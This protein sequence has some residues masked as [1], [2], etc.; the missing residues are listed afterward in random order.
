MA[1]LNPNQIHQ[2]LSEAGLR[3]KNAGNLADILAANSLSPEDVISELGSMARSA[4]QEPT[5]LK[6]LEL[7]M[8]LNGMLQGDDSKQIPIVNI[9]IQDAQ[10]FSVNPILIPR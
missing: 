1:L 6:A 7:G 5:R 10:N 9:I 8:K 2:V 4:T 3:P